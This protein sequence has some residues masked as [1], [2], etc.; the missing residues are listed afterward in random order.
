ML[1]SSYVHNGYAIETYN[2]PLSGAANTYGSWEN[3]HDGSSFMT[4]GFPYTIDLLHVNLCNVGSNAANRNSY[5]DIGIGAT[6][7]AVFPLVEK[8]GGPGSAP[9]LGLSYWIPICIPP[10]MPVWV[11]HQNVTASINV[12]IYINAFGGNQNIYTMPTISQVVALGAT[13]ASTVGTTLTVGSSGAEG[14]WTQIVASTTTDYAGCLISWFNSGTTH[15][16]A[17][18]VYSFDVAVGASGQEKSIGE[19]LTRA[20]PV[21]TS[22][23]FVAVCNPT[24]VGIPAGSR[25]SVRGSCTGIPVT[26]SSVIINAFTH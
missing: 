10:N 24:L 14:A 7:N 16:A 3:L 25:L 15:G 4:N 21:N 5:V 22:E 12:A 13:S 20:T 9:Y 11:R 1:Q 8:L 23:Q 18:V 17:N 2:T 6:S 26:T 19:N